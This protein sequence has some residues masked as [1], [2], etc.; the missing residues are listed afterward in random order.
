M[1]KVL[2]AEQM[3][4]VDRLTTEKYGIP[5]IILM[6]NAAYAVSRVITE[7]LGGSVVGRR[8][9]ILCGTGNNGGDGAALARILWTQGAN[10]FVWLFGNVSDTLG[11]AKVNFEAIKKFD[12]S[13]DTNGPNDNCLILFEDAQIRYPSFVHQSDD[14]IVD[15]LF[16]TGLSRPLDGLVGELVDSLTL[17]KKRLRQVFL[18]IDI[19]SGLQSDIGAIIGPVF[20]ADCTVTFTSPKPA[21]ILPPAENYNGELVVANIGSPDELIDAQTSHLYLTEFK[22]A[23]RWLGTTAFSDSSYKNK[24]GHA[25]VIAGSGSYSGT[26]VLC[27]NAA[28][29]SGVGLVTI[30]TPKSSKDSVVSRV[31]PEVMVKGVAETESGAIAELAFDE[32]SDLLEKADAVAIGSGLA[33]DESTKKFVEKVLENRRQPTIVDADALNLLSPFVKHV[34]SLHRVSRPHVSKGIAADDTSRGFPLILT[35]HEGEFMRLL[36]TDDKDATKDRVAAVRDFATTYNVILVLKGERVLIGEPGGKVVVNPTGNSG[37]GKAG[38]GDTLTGILVGFVAQATQ[39]NI[40]IFET[41]VA[42]VYV[43]GMAGDIAER[44]Y[45]KRVMTASDVRECLVDVF[46]E[47]GGGS[48]V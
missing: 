11:D 34:G 26:A 31:L 13:D 12:D 7:K 45:G 6:E 38:N 29:R 32:L 10:C 2:T 4:E 16:G 8:F 15:A 1:Q 27:G 43:A 40:G 39:F 9:N 3:R 23:K 22:D 47:L 42:A 19:P 37:L 28:M 25:L 24:R 5:S 20:P 44:K 36:G 21:N 35:P 14:F 17:R 30:A 46:A 41:V 48:A 33:Q 18:A